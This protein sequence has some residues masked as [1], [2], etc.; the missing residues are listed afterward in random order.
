MSFRELRIAPTITL[1]VGG[2]ILLAVGLVFYLQ[3]KS[4]REIMS[5]L[6]GRVALRLCG[7]YQA[8]RRKPRITGN[9][10]AQIKSGCG[11]RTCSRSYEPGARKSCLRFLG[12]RRRSLMPPNRRLPP[13]T[14]SPLSG[15]CEI[16]RLRQS[17]LVS[18]RNCRSPLM[19]STNAGT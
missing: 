8:D 1:N 5:E 14:G 18:T 7:V 11:G 2:M 16:R 10:G 6:A 9:R 3:W 12:L 13:S 17:V 19:G 15:Q 4:S